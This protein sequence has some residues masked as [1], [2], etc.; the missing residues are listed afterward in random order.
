MGNSQKLG[1]LFE[2][3]IS[4]IAVYWEQKDMSTLISGPRTLNLASQAIDPKPEAL[5]LN[6]RI[7]TFCPKLH[8][9]RHLN[10]LNLE[11]ESLNT[12]PN[13]CI[14]FHWD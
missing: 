13:I 1:S 8:Q 14:H 7:Y 10:H 11:F 5:N 12:E 4:W 3:P 6:H 9:I 2:V